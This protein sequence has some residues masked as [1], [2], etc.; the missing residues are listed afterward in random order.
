MENIIVRFADIDDLPQIVEIYNQAIETKLSTGDIYPF[1]VKERIAWFHDHDKN[2][3]PLIVALSN[4]K[5]VGYIYL[6]PYRKGRD[7]LKGTVEVSYYVH[8]KFQQKGVGS[9]LLETMISRAIS[10]GYET[11]IAIIFHVN[12]GSIKLLEKFDF[13]KWG[14]LPDVIHIDNEKYSHFYYGLKL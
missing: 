5:I 4:E 2:K 1:T 9:V 12:I 11:I 7:G 6:S 3:Y 13:T 10:L 14:V 8:N